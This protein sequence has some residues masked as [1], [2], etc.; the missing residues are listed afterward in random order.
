MNR[1]ITYACRFLVTDMVSFFIIG[2]FIKQE[3]K[4]FTYS[5]AFM[6]FMLSVVTYI[7]GVIISSTKGKNSK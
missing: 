2:L 3:Y 6:F 5:G 1:Y 7:Y 4:L